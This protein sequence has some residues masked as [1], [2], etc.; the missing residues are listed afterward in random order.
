ML[1]NLLSSLSRLPF[2]ADH[3]QA[4][5]PGSLMSLLILASLKHLHSAEQACAAVR[6]TIIM[7]YPSEPPKPPP[8]PTPLPPGYQVLHSLPP[9]RQHRCSTALTA[10]C[11]MYRTRFA[12]CG[13]PRP[14]NSAAASGPVAA[15]RCGGA[16]PGNASR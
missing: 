4:A 9:C 15:D 5:Q 6:C 12:D 14:A 16:A 13:I 8:L 2:V 7:P 10:S 1:P 3:G 11:Y